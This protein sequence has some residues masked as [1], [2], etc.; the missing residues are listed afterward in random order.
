MVRTV[1]KLNLNIDNGIS[2]ENA[3]VE[4]ALNT[5][6][7]RGNK[8]LRDRTADNSVDELIALAAFVRG[9]AD[10][11]RTDRNRPTDAYTSYQHRHCL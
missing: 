7:Y 11:D 8:F 4:R 3:R 6:V 10:F 2:R 1:V 9:Y 5:L